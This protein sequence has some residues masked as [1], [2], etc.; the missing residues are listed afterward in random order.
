M[1]K[2][3]T[4]HHCETEFDAYPDDEAVFHDAQP[5]KIKVKCPGCFSAGSSVEEAIYVVNLMTMQ[6]EV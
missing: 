3:Y 4:C 5:E 1:N 6:V 2:P